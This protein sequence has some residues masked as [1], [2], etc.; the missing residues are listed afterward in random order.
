MSGGVDSSVAAALLHDEGWDVVGITM[1]TWDHATTGGRAEARGRQIGC[2]TL[3]SMNDAR[4]VAV[5]RGFPHYVVDLREEFGDTVISRFTSEYLAGRTP[6]PCVLCNTHVKWDALLRRADALGCSHIATGHYARVGFDEA[7]G[8]WR[9]QRGVDRA[10]DQSYALWG[11]AQEHL[12]RTILPLGARTKPEIRRLAAD[13]GLE[14]VALKSDSYEICF[15]PDDDY[16]AF[17]RRRAPAEMA[18]LA[19]GRL[20]HGPTGQVVGRHEGH[21]FFTVGQRRGL[22]VTLGEPVY[23]VD[24]DATTNTVT[25]GPRSWLDGSSLTARGVVFSGAPGMRDER[26]VLAQTRYSGEAVGALA[27]ETEHGEVEVVFTEARPA[28]A[29]GQAVVLYGEDEAVLAGGWVAR[30]QPARGAPRQAPDRH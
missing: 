29:P 24:I 17:L 27:T 28:P 25:V 3:E 11:V 16:R 14:H 2:C 9:V 10:K 12:A 4:A 21:P 20:V 7:A 22:G 5:G 23:V 15:I 1:K 13:L 6:N 30:V 19:G 26:F 8:R 18:V